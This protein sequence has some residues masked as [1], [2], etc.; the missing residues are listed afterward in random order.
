MN[1]GAVDGR[2][3]RVADFSGVIQCTTGWPELLNKVKTPLSPIEIQFRCLNG[4]I[5]LQCIC[6]SEVAQSLIRLIKQ[7]A[8]PVH[9]LHSRFRRLKRGQSVLW[10]VQVEVCNRG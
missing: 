8:T 1:D 6:A 7:R 9:S 2:Y 3:F 10:L 4:R 5:G